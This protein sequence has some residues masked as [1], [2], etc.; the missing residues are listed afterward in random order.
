M[1]AAAIVG[2]KGALGSVVSDI[3]VREGVTDVL[4]DG[5]ELLTGDSEELAGVC[6]A[7]ELEGLDLVDIKPVESVG[8]G[9]F[10]V[11]SVLGPTGIIVSTSGIEDELEI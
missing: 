6:G 9:V 11:D 7:S 5:P 3:V 10:V 8:V 4:V 2:D 1:P